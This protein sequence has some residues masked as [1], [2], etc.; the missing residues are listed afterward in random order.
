MRHIL[1]G[2]RVGMRLPFGLGLRDGTS[3]CSVF[4]PTTNAALRAI[5]ARPTRRY[6]PRGHHQLVLIAGEAQSSSQVLVGQRPI[7]EQVIQVI[8]TFL[9]VDL[10]RFGFTFVL[11]TRPG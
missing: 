9:Q 11:R 6:V 3:T 10:E 4:S 7:A 1:F 2:D 5:H 8:L